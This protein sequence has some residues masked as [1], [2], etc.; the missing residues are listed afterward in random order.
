MDA[1]LP[2]ALPD[3][4]LSLE[5][6]LSR[7]SN[8]LLQKDADQ[9][10]STSSDQNEVLH[11]GKEEAAEVARLELERAE[12]KARIKAEN[13]QRRLALREMRRWLPH[14]VPRVRVAQDLHLNI[15]P[16]HCHG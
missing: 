6:H 8:E 9:L 14:S 1:E 5:Q 16:D 15:C 2:K 3:P 11:A 7:P 4:A 10:P 13:K 12:E